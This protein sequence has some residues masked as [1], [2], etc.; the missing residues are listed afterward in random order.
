[1]FSGM[2]TFHELNEAFPSL[3]REDGSRKP[4][5]EF[6]KDVQKVDKTYNGRYLKA[7]YN[8]ANASADMAARWERF[9][10]SDRYLLQYRTQND[11][12]VRPEHAALHG[13][14]L[15]ASDS[16]WDTYF[17][18]N[19]WN[20]R[21]T[22]VQVL[23]D[24]YPETDHNEAMR[25]GREAMTKDTKGMFSFNPGKQGKV[26]PDYNPYTISRCATCDKAKLNLGA[27][28]PDNEVCTACDINHNT[29]CERS[30]D[31]QHITTAEERHEIY[32]KP[33]DEQ[34]ESV[35][36][37]GNAEVV[38][39]ILKSTESE[40]YK[41]VLDVA[42]AMAVA[43]GGKIWILPEIHK[44]ETEFRKLLG[45][46]TDKGHTPDI[47]RQIGHFVDVKS[48]ESLEK[49]S[50]NA[51]KAFKQ[52]AV[53]CITDHSCE[54]SLQ[55][56]HQYAKWILGSQGY[57]YNEVYFYIDDILIKKAKK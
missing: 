55:D 7:E 17:P 2:K 46:P 19:G 24:K 8:I 41:R 16:F 53:A 9:G 32:S 26:F 6:L 11:G 38:R 56:I 57:H 30:R 12:A 48:P 31:A 27:H 14:T 33:I 20:C 4:F 13:V 50:A 10:D 36:N 5:K 40:D 25:L 42:R 18:P 21:C 37:N 52:G 34:F 28:I 1:M 49:L 45:L 15:P 23:R 29:L 43:E 39:H 51:C 3:I 22:V 44:S 47:M 35:Y 54:M